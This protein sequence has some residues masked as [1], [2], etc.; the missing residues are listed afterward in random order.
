MN[1]R[2]ALRLDRP[3]CI[4]FVGAGGKT[5]AMFRLARELPPPVIVTTTTHLG[6][7]QTCLGDRWIQSLDV[8]ADA[9]FAADGVML[10]TGQVIKD[11]RVAGLEPVEMD[12]LYA[13]AR[14]NGWSLLVEC[15]GSRQLPL[16]APAAHE[17]VIPTWV[18]QVV[19]VA[20]LQGLGKPCNNAYIHRAEL[21]SKLT[22]LPLE[23]PVGEE[24]LV[25]EL[26]NPL[27]GQKGIPVSAQKIVLLNQAD[28]EGLISAA[29][30]MAPALL[31]GFDAV[32]TG[33]LKDDTECEIIH[34]REPLAG[35]ILA[36]GGSTRLGVPKQ[37]LTWRGKSFIENVIQCG[38]DAGLQKMVVVTNS[39]YSQ[40]IHKNY[41]QKID[42][43]N[44]PTWQSG[45]STSVRLG[46]QSLPANTGGAVLLL[47][48]Q[49]HIPARLVRAL[50]D[51]HAEVHAPII[52]PSVA[53]KR[54]NPVLFDRS[55]FSDLLSVEGDKGGRILFAKY[56]AE[57]IPWDDESILLDVDTSEDY[58]RLRELE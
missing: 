7:W 38:L 47:C 46:V 14:E 32:L 2:Q 50:I 26:L 18:D 8:F 23:E 35:V 19:T 52:A 49:P 17:P 44:N 3:A 9:G 31:S 48:D 24:A 33:R 10:V 29:T 45:L 21:F 37:G 42:L 15:D 6:I 25:K 36:A 30:R 22:D 40:F 56:P 16:K 20:G 5:S 43:I 11:E 1:L 53:G 54:A 4:A 13:I 51:R 55:T 39:A 57:Y 58:A 27:G 28:D 12:R 34:A 41:L